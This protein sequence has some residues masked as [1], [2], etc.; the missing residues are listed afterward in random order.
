MRTCPAYLNQRYLHYQ[1]LHS[2]CDI[3][4]AA[5][6]RKTYRGKEFLTVN[7]TA[8]ELQLSPATVRRYCDKGE[9]RLVR[10]RVNNYRYVSTHSIEALKKRFRAAAEAALT[11]DHPPQAARAQLEKLSVEL[12]RLLVRMQTPQARAGME[13]A[14]EASPKQL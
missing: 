4:G 6:A 14:F 13:S 7:G 2:W 5:M 9:L 12:D 11:S 8:R 1:P 3:A 10:N